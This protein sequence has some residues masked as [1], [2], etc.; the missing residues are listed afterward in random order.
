[1][2]MG[3]TRSRLLANFPSNF[4]FAMMVALLVWMTRDAIL[5]FFLAPLVLMLV[6]QMATMARLLR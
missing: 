4:G 5:L 1:M 2:V 6:V 3:S